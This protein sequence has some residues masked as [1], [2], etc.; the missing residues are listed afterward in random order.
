M[1]TVATARA[2]GAGYRLH[3]RFSNRPS[4]CAHHPVFRNPKREGGFCGHFSRV[5]VSDFRSL[6]RD[7]VF[8]SLLARQSPAAKIPFQTRIGQL[9]VL[10]VLSM[11]LFGGTRSQNGIDIFQ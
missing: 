8:K 3:V 5:V 6:R 4:W 1:S 7:I 2:Y 11:I 10:S 9:I